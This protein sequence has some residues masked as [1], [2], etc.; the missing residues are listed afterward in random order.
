[1]QKGVFEVKSTNGDTHLGGEDFDIVLV[2]HL[3]NEFKKESGL[4]LSKDR[5]AIQ[6]IREAAEKAKIELSSTQQT[7]ISLPYITADASGPKHINSKMTDRSSN[8]SSASSSTHRRAMQEGAQRR[9]L[10]AL[11][12]PGG[13]H[14]RRYEPNAQGSRDGQEHLQA[15]PKQG[16]KPRRG[17]RLRC[18]DPGWCSLGQVTDVLLLD[19]TPL[20]LGIQTLG[21]VFTRLINRNTTIP[22]KKSQVFSTAA[23]GQTAVDIQ[24]YQG[25][26]VSSFVTT[27]CS[28]TS[29]SPV[30]RLRPR[31]FPGRGHL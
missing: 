16:C 7:D 9:R 12:H 19:V 15:R 1:M 4:D 11:G 21:G 3:V 8:R 22:T 29:S 20:S 27:S 2:E 30:S 5:M 14:G 13:H 24:V 10:Q 18:L 6:R 28:A 23:D 25:E 31:V 17:R 26:R